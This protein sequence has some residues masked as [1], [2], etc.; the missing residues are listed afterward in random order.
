LTLV[1]LLLLLTPALAPSPA[2]AA[3]PDNPFQDL[4]ARIGVGHVARL[5]GAI[6][7]ALEIGPAH[8]PAVEAHVGLVGVPTRILPLPGP[9]GVWHVRMANESPLPLLVPA[10]ET[11]I[12]P[13][14]PSRSTDRPVWIAPGAATF[15]PVVQERTQGDPPQGPYVSRGRG[16]TPVELEMIPQDRWATRVRARNAQLGVPAPRITD[17]AAAY[18]TDAFA[19]VLARYQPELDALV[20]PSSVVGVMVADDRGIHFAHVLANHALFLAAWPALRDG[21]VLDAAMLEIVGSAPRPGDETELRRDAAGLLRVLTAPPL[22]RPN[23]GEGWE[24]RWALSDPAGTWDGLGLDSGPVCLTLH[25]DPP[26]ATGA[27]QPPGTGPSGG[28]PENGTPGLLE[29]ERRRRETEFERRLRER[30]EGMPNGPRLPPGGGTS[31]PSNPGAT[32]PP[33]PS[34]SPAPAPSPAPGPSVPGRR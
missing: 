32:P 14:E 29:G 12:T 26:R 15:V 10:G 27:P 25:R 1:C 13:T 5:R 18:A 22:S 4:A 11:L 24:Y 6:V 20:R 16:L 9:A 7:A 3:A 21:I 34:P 2:A 31:P 17:A 33:T 30:R 8:Q 23:F 28:T 19:E